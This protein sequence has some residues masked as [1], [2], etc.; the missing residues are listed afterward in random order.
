MAHRLLALCDIHFDVVF[1]RLAAERHMCYFCVRLNRKQCLAAV[2]A[3]IPETT[4]DD[5]YH[6][7][8]E[9]QERGRRNAAP[10]RLA[11]WQA[12]QAPASL[13]F[14]LSLPS[15]CGRYEIYHLK[16]PTYPTLIIAALFRIVKDLFIFGQAP[17]FFFPYFEERDHRI[18]IGGVVRRR[19]QTQSQ[20]K[21]F[22]MF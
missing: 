22:S 21:I 6:I 1:A 8:S 15:A 10:R 14:P 12:Y 3:A 19:H 13:G 4:V 17:P 16:A 20:P 7:P 9:M 18:F 5:F 11:L 2:R